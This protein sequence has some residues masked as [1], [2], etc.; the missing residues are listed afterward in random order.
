MNIIKLKDVIMPDMY[1]M[2]K[3]F[4]AYLK[5]KYAYWIQM[6]YIVPFDLMRHEGYVACEEDI[7]KLLINVDGTYPRPY[8]CPYIDMYDEDACILP[9][10]DM[11]ETDHINNIS[12]FI[13]E[14]NKST[15]EDLTISELKNF[16][17]WLAGSLYNLDKIKDELDSS[18]YN[19]RIVK[20][21]LYYTNNM[22]NDT[23]KELNLFNKPIISTNITSCGCCQSENIFNT[24]IN[25]CDAVSNYRRNVYNVMVETFSDISFWSN[26]PQDFLKRMKQYIDNIIK[27]GLKLNNTSNITSVYSTCECKD[28]KNNNEYILKRLS[29]SLSYI[30][31]KEYKLHNNYIRDS[32][33]DWATY[34]YEYMQW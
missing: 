21:L 14:N 24:N 3:F 4:N 29:E 7:T 19:E 10:I 6:H 11:V 31:N 2:S 15:D 30:I 23:I 25:D 28:S 5:G 18:K 12:R 27:V 13:V 1:K 9:Y 33:N 17:T 26:L 16:R 20:M 34:L 32:F 8:G 22:M